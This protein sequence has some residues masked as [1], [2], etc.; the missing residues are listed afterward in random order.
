MGVPKFY[1]WLKKQGYEGVLI[2]KG[3]K[4]MKVSSFLFDLNGLI[5]KAAQIV[6]AYGEWHNEKKIEQIKTMDSRLLESQFHQELGKLLLESIADVNPQEILVLAVDG[7]APQ[8]KITQQRQRR[9]RSAMENSSGPVF[10]S[11]CITPGTDF[12]FRLDAFVK[13]WIKSNQ[14]RLPSTVIYSS[15][16]VPGEGEHKIIDMMRDGRIHGDGAHVIY[17]M[18]ADLIMLGLLAPINNIYLAREDIHDVISIDNL[19]G[20]LVDRLAVNGIIDEN[21]VTETIQSFVVMTFLIGNDFLPHMPALE[22]LEH[23]MNELFHVYRTVNR[24]LVTDFDIN[25]ENMGLFFTELARDEPILLTNE[26]KRIVTY[27]SRFLQMAS[28]KIDIINPERLDNSGF[29]IGV[30]VT[31]QIEFNYPLFRGLWYQNVFAPKGNSDIFRLF[32]P[33]VNFFDPTVEEILVMCGEYLKGIAWVFHYYTRGQKGVNINYVYRYHHAPLIS[34]LAL[35][36]SAPVNV[37]GYLY[38]QGQVML[39]PVHQLLAVLPSKSKTFLPENVQYL[40]TENSPIADLY[41]LTAIIERDGKDGSWQGVVLIPFININRII[42]AV[43]TISFSH[44][45]VTQFSI[46]T[47]HTFIRNVELEPLIQKEQQFRQMLAQQRQLMYG[48]RESN[49]TSNFQHKGRG[50]GGGG[51]RGGGR[52]NGRG[53][54]RGRVE[55]SQ[56]KN[57]QKPRT[58]TFVKPQNRQLQPQPQQISSQY[59]VTNLQN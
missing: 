37:T 51:G 23:S 30:N 22:D 8:A 32:L 35:V 50:R 2:N 29:G 14:W 26:A 34:D 43:S 53:R 46:G 25:W 33:T 12:M 7:V 19:R 18:D 42:E 1:A 39:N 13:G 27:P 28:Q 57:P 54:G 3:F 40:M 48:N 16:M 11:N 45:V 56:N 59:Q 55:D 10:D 4:G 9:F 24:P 44:K 52:G 21:T 47:E 49:S 20:A 38:E 15:H 17:G 58:F 6:Y 31:N 36:T 41:P 5:H